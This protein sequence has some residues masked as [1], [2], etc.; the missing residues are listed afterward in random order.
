MVLVCGAFGF[1]SQ[2]HD[3]PTF[4]CSN[5]YKVLVDSNPDTKISISKL[6][7]LKTLYVFHCSEDGKSVTDIADGFKIQSFTFAIAPKS[8]ASHIIHELGCNLNAQS[9]TFLNSVHIGD[10]FIIAEIKV[11]G[12][13]AKVYIF[14]GPTYI[15]VA[16]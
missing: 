13:D 4:A 9:K 16:D 11:I 8:G 2:G 10:L 15:A 5:G 14:S 1:V 7:T 6:A 12:P 3:G